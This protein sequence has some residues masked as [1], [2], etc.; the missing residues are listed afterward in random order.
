[1]MALGA[2][3]RPGVVYDSPLRSID[4]VPSIGAMMG[5]QASQSQG[6]PIKELL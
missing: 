6:S 3:V 4:I 2:G 1:M 5:F